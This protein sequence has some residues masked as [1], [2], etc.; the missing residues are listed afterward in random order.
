MRNSASRRHMSVILGLILAATLLVMAPPAHAGTP[1]LDV[2]DF[3]ARGDGSTDDTAAIQAALD[4]AATLGASVFLP[5]G[6]FRVSRT[7]S[8][9]AL[10][11]PSGVTLHGGGD[12]SMLRLA[13]GQGAGIRVVSA[14]DAEN[15]GL[16]NLA[17]DGNDA[18]QGGWDPQ[19]HAVFF[20]AVRNAHI[21]R[22]TIRNVAGDG[23][24]FHDRTGGIIEDS[25]FYAGPDPRIGI[26]LSGA[27]DAVVRN[28]YIEGWDW[29]VKAEV[30]GGSPHAERVLV[31][32][33]E[34]AA[35]KDGGTALHGRDGTFVFEIAGNRLHS[36]GDRSL[37]LKGAR[38]LRLVGN[39]VSGG[40]AAVQVVADVQD[41]DIR[42]NEF[43][44]QEAG[45][46]LSD[47]YASGPST[48]V[49]VR[50]NLFRRASYAAAVAKA[51]IVPG[52]TVTGNQLPASGGRVVHQQ[53]YAGAPVTVAGNVVGVAVQPLPYTPENI[54]PTAFGVDP[55]VGY[56]DPLSLPEDFLFADLSLRH[57]HAPAV[58][59]L[60]EDGIVSGY[61]DG[62]FGLEHPVRR[63][64]VAKMAVVAFDLHDEGLAAAPATFPDVP[65]TGVSYPVDF[66]AEAVAAGLVEGY[67]DGTFAP[68]VR[69]SASNSCES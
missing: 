9:Y 45:M 11:L 12:A 61:P 7:G 57:P 17:I 14:K 24:Y 41:G 56:P 53:A 63:V 6:S 37:W 62:R 35:L 25:R 1:A 18:R 66:V 65:A 32:G 42:S 3:G 52:L 26:N 4:R 20:S 38:R 22:V 36:L 23:I 13:D 44:D 47:P 34:G 59:Y 54:D 68:D 19:N 33:N 55:P 50:D 27:V 5:P 2:S 58:Q 31:S 15:V 39:K 10:R 21:R 46:A 51:G 49:T 8:N 30:N 43:I 64:Q 69:S 48:T 67:P 16:Q 28:S 40:G 60:V 29:A